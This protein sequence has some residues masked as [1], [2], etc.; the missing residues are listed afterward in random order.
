MEGFNWQNY[1]E[2]GNQIANDPYQAPGQAPDDFRVQGDTSLNIT[3]G[4]T[5]NREILDQLYNYGHI[6]D[7]DYNRMS[8][9]FGES[10][11]GSKTGWSWGKSP[12]EMIGWLPDNL[13]PRF[14][15]TNE[16]IFNTLGDLNPNTEKYKPNEPD[17][18]S[19][20]Q[21]SLQ[22]LIQAMTSQGGI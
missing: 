13:H 8:E 11:S 5:T 12:E 17:V 21:Q 14:R 18:A 16:R 3:P 22:A 20:D 9:S 19:Y 7:Y 4:E 1:D 6:S 2:S 10:G 15:E